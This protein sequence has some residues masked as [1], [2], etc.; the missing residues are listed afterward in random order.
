MSDENSYEVSE[1]DMPEGDGDRE[2]RV[3]DVAS[4]QKLIIYSSFSSDVSSIE[5]PAM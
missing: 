2:Y 3:E 5:S 1:E 4:G